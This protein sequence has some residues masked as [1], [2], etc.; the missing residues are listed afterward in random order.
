M[1]MQRPC[2]SRSLKTGRLRSQR[3]EA[4]GTRGPAQSPGLLGHGL[5]GLEFL[6]MYHDM[7]MMPQSEDS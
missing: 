1:E 3:L 6:K 5:V 2:A 7:I 4:K